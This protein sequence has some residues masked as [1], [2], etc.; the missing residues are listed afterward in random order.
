M[1]SHKSFCWNQVTGNGAISLIPMEKQ[2]WGEYYGRL[3]APFG[4]KWTIKQM[5]QHLSDEEVKDAVND[6]LNLKK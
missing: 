5:I 3:K 4:H 6:M 1:L 2:F